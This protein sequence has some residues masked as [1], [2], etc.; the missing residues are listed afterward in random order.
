MV[1]CYRDATG[2]VGGL[3]V[4]FTNCAKSVRESIKCVGV[5]RKNTQNGVKW[6]QNGVVKCAD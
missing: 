3:G 2:H 4:F 5:V 6:Y 1:Q